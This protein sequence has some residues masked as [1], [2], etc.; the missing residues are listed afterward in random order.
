MLRDGGHIPAPATGDRVDMV[1]ALVDDTEQTW[2]EIHPVW[3]LRING[4]A[5][6]R[7]GPRDGGDP[8][9][10]PLLQRS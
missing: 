6:S 7:S 1:G 4:G 9:G 8:P 2:T 3:A 10:G 5:W